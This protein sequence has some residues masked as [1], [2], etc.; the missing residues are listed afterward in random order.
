MM[1]KD[2]TINN[3][4]AKDQIRQEM[5]QRLAAMPYEKRKAEND[6]LRERFFT[7]TPVQQASSFFIYYNIGNE[8]FTKAIIQIL[9]NQGKRVALPVCTPEK[10]LRAARINNLYEVAQARYGLMEPTSTSFIASGELDLI[11]LP[12]LAFDLSGHRLGRG[13]GYYDR[14]LPSAPQAYKLGLAYDC[15]LLDKLPQDTWD[16][17]MDGVLTGERVI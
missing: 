11:V 1:S 10:S 15:Q 17:K 7:L 6:A 12:G 5:R 16:I 8:V 3:T 14:F 9:L 2:E 4:A 13:A